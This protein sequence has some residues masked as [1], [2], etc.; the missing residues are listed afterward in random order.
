MVK[1]KLYLD[2]YIFVGLKNLNTGF[3]VET[4]KYFSAQDFEVVMER[5]K[6]QSLGI[7]GIEPWKNGKFYG[8]LTNE[9]FTKDPTDSNWYL[10]A[11]QKFKESGETLQYAASYYVPD[12]KLRSI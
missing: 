1:E 11:F 2:K 10:K 12:E 5:I 8:V 7:T 6:Q 4:I 3:D 9:E